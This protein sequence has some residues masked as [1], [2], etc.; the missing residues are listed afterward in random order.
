M[1]HVYRDIFFILIAQPYCCTIHKPESSPVWYSPLPPCS[2]VSLPRL[3]HGPQ[4]CAESS[5]QRETQVLEKIHQG[6]S[7]Q[8]EQERWWESP[9]D[10]KKKAYRRGSWALNVT[11]CLH[12]SSAGHVTV[13]LGELSDGGEKSEEGKKSGSPGQFRRNIPMVFCCGVSQCNF[14]GCR[15]WSISWLYPLMVIKKGLEII[16]F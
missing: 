1:K 2:P 6:S 16:D 4:S 5:R 8:K 15:I 11:K 7:T 9:R 13:D 12:V 14:L 3:D 10:R